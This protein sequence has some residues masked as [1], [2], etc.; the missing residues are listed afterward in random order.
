MDQL[1]TL[2]Y[3]SRSAHHQPFQHARLC[4]NRA[5]S[6]LFAF[7]DVVTSCTP[8]AVAVSETGYNYSLALEIDSPLNCSPFH[9]PAVQKRATAPSHASAFLNTQASHS[10]VIPFAFLPSFPFHQPC[11]AGTA[12]NSKSYIPR[13]PTFHLRP[14]PPPPLFNTTNPPFSP[15]TPRFLQ[16]TSRLRGRQNRIRLCRRCQRRRSTFRRLERLESH[17]NVSRRCW[18]LVRGHSRPSRSP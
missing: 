5:L 17:P 12:A 6:K 8:F 11:S 4:T 15:R 18:H 10:L 7:I 2:A 1:C 3:P 9:S 13:S 16:K 14:P